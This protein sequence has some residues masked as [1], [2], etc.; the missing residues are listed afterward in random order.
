MFSNHNTT[1]LKITSKGQKL[2]KNKNTIFDSNN[3]LGGNKHELLR[4]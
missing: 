2:K 1:K 4:I 3:S